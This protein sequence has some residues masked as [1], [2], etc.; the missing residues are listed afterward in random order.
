MASLPTPVSSRERAAALL[1]VLAFVVLLTGLSVAYLSRTTGDRQVADSSFNQSSVDQLAQSA[2]DN[3]IGEIRQEITDGSTTTIVNVNGVAVTIYTPTSPANMVPQRNVSLPGVPNLVR[4]SGSPDPPAPGLSTRASAV[5]S[6]TSVSANGRY[7]TSTRWNGHY[8]VPKG[9]VLTS[10]SSPVPA[11]TT[12]DWV[13]VTSAG[14][15][16]SPAPADVIGRYAYAIYDEG[17]LLDANMVGLPSPSPG[18]VSTP[19]SIPYSP[20]PSPGPTVTYYTGRKGTVA[21]A[22]LTA[23]P[24]TAGVTPNPTTISKIV[25]WR[26]LV[27]ATVRITGGGGGGPAQSFPNLSPSPSPFVSY[28]LDNSRDFLTV[29]P[30]T[31]SVNRTDQAFV[32]RSALIQ[33]V[34]NIGDANPAANITTLL[35]YLGTFSREQNSPTWQ[36]ATDPIAQRFQLGKL[37]FLGNTPLSPVGSSPSPAPLGTPAA[38]IKAA[39]GLQWSTT[40]RRWQYVGTQGTSLL[41]AIVPPAPGG[42]PAPDFFQ[43]LSYAY[44]NPGPT[45]TIDKILSLGAAIIDQYDTDQVTTAIE[46]GPATTPQPVA[47]GMEDLASPIPMGSAS[48]TPPVPPPTPIPGYSPMLQRPFQN[49]GELGYAYN[50]VTGATVNFYTSGS[51]DGALLDLFTYNTTDN[52]ATYGLPYPLRAGPVNINTRN[53]AVIAALLKSASMRNESPPIT[54]VSSP[55][56]TPAASLIAG[57]T[58]TQP[59]I[60]RQEITRLVEAVGTTIGSTEEDKETVAR[61]LSDTT[62]TRTWGLLIDVVAQSGKYAPGE[63]D[64][65]K[66]NVTGEQHYW[67]HVAIDRF[68]GRVLDKQIEVVNE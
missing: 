1:I 17:G 38:N 14:A 9:S 28:F 22:D 13:F 47:W 57:A 64:L 59:A 2:M 48:P 40:F 52:T 4:R 33:L 25:G 46:Y 60:S 50:P 54:L 45:P 32:T 66:F 37:S 56:A 8:L 15:T 24:L 26:N 12:P 5:N 3:I 53:S 58:S 61:A 19:F 36:S 35:Q 27:S 20:T 31:N 29:Y 7:V 30:T 62:Q 67:V 6:T 21:F 34:L 39:F 42:S 16:P 68:T 43:I 44:S 63:T 55:S 41:S 18:A 49:V 23:L 10:D 65:R 51:S 11:F